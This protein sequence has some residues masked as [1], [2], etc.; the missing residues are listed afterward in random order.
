MSEQIQTAGQA[1]LAA[2]QSA[3]QA[4]SAAALAAATPTRRKKRTVK[5]KAAN[6]G[7]AGRLVDENHRT[8]TITLPKETLAWYEQLASQAPFEPSVQKYIA[9]ELRQLAAQHRQTSQA[10]PPEATVE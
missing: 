7:G 10:E 6:D 9:W 1:A 5:P 2:G 3:G 4:A 8:V